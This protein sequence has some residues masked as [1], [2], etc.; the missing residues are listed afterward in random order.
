MKQPRKIKDWLEILLVIAAI[1]LIPL[2]FAIRSRA[3]ETANTVSASG[4][5]RPPPHPRQL[6]WLHSQ[7]PRL[8]WPTEKNRLHAPSR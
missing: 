5:A 2:F 3:G 7:P 6:R 4:T 8:W 1:I